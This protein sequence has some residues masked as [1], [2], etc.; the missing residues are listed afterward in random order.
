MERTFLHPKIHF[1]KDNLPVGL[2][3]G[4]LVLV[5]A[6]SVEDFSLLSFLDGV[7]EVLAPVYI[8]IVLPNCFDSLEVQV[9][10]AST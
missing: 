10:G 2:R 6:H 4:E 3:L 1:G 9:E 5:N 8:G 7:E